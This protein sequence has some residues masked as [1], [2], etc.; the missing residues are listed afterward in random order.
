MVRL[1]SALSLYY[2]SEHHS[3]IYLHLDDI[4]T[5]VAF[6]KIK[7]APIPCCL[8]LTTHDVEHF[9]RCCF[10]NI[11]NHNITCRIWVHVAWRYELWNTKHHVDDQR[12]NYVFRRKIIL[13]AWLLGRDVNGTG[14]FDGRNVAIDRDD[15]FVWW[16]VDNRKTRAR[17]C[18]QFNRTGV[19]VNI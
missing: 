9:N 11:N 6:W 2:S 16:F 3:I 5:A 1:L 18:W 15:L 4:N 12:L 14:L 13:I 19:A 8:W 10:W 17:C 7:D